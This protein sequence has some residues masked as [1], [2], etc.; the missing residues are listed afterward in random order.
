MKPIQQSAS[1]AQAFLAGFKTLYGWLSSEPGSTL[2]Q[3]YA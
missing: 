3:K 2:A 1:P